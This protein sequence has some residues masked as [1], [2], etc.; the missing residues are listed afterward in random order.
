MFNRRHTAKS[1][2]AMSENHIGER[3]SSYGKHWWTNPETFEMKLLRDNEVPEGWFRKSNF[4]KE[5]K[6]EILLS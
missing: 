1:K 2:A 4:L 5:K 3:N 6:Q